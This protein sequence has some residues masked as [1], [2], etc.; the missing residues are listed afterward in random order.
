MKNNAKSKNNQQKL[1]ALS[2]SPPAISITIDEWKFHNETFPLAKQFSPP[3]VENNSTPN[4]FEQFEQF[5]QGNSAPDHELFSRFVPNYN[6]ANEN[7]ISEQQTQYQPQ[8]VQNIP[9]EHLEL[10]PNLSSPIYF[11]PNINNEDSDHYSEYFW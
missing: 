3:S 8:Y 2:T 1:P 10:E 9:I 7:Y 11:D 5:E 6:P 4:L